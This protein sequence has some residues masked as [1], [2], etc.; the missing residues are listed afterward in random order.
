[1]VCVYIYIHMYISSY[2]LKAPR[3]K[4]SL[5]K[6]YWAAMALLWNRFE[7]RR[8]IAPVEASFCG[9]ET[10][11]VDDWIYMDLSHYISTQMAE[12]SLECM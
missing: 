11:M 2:L 7:V 8:G 4:K 1:M 10:M 3:L 9:N 6:P 5:G 12:R